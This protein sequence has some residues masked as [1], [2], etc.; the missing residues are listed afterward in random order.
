MFRGS[1]DNVDVDLTYFLGKI[2]VE[3]ERARL[4]LRLAHMKEEDGEPIEVYPQVYS[5][6]L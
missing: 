4:R 3:V 5:S 1:S 6:Y 2:F